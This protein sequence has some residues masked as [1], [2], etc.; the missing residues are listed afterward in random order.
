VSVRRFVERL[1]RGERHHAA[2]AGDRA[3]IALLQ[4]GQPV[5]S[6][7]RAVDPVDIDVPT[8]RVDTTNG[9]TPDVDA[10]IAFVR[11]TVGVP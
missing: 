10:I 4:A 7:E 1:E 3:R 11:T 2:I 8:L 5:D 9:Y 6:W